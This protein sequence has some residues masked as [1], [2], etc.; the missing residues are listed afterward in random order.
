MPKTVDKEEVLRL[1][2]CYQKCS[3]KGCVEPLYT[4]YNTIENAKNFYS[5]I[6]D[7]Y[8]KAI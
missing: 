1:I 7:E 5:A 3:Y 4:E 2:C 6:I 8:S